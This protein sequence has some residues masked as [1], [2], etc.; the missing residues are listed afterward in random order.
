MKPKSSTTVAGLRGRA[1]ARLKQ[2]RKTQRTDDGGQRSAADT[3]RLLHELQVHQ[4]ELELQN[5][6]LQESRDEAEVAL[7]KYTE[8]YDFAPVGYFSL[9]EQGR[10]LAVNLT[11]AALLGVERS[12]LT[13]RPLQRFVVPASR[14]IFLAFLEKVFAT[15]DKQVCEVSILDEDGVAFWVDL[16]GA[17]LPSPG[18]A[19]LSCRV[20]ASDITALKR[21][22]E[23]QRRL[24]ALAAINRELNLEIVR[25]QA[26]EAALKESEVRQGRLLEQSQHMQ[27]QLRRLSHQI[28]QAH[29]EERKRIS[30]ELH[31][32][33]T[34]TLVGINVHLET[35][36]RA[37]EANPRQL[38]GKIVRTQR[39]VEK[40]VSMVHRFARELRPT[41]LDDL[42][43]VATVHS[44]LKDFTKRT[45]IRVHFTSFASGRIDQLASDARTVFYRVAQ[46]A[47]TN[48]ARHAEA[49]QVKV[50]LLKLPEALCL[51]ISDNGKSFAVEKVMDPKRNQRL[52]LIG[53]RERVEMVGGSLSIE[54]APGQGTTI[55]AQIP[56][57]ARS[58]R[59]KKL[60][61]RTVKTKPFLFSAPVSTMPESSA[62]GISQA[63]ASTQTQLR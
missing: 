3:Q 12:R 45:G 20:A 54:S 61:V 5:A 29:E 34:Q 35:L 56:I 18:G 44:F 25:R 46:E 10:I 42:G 51:E 15:P 55:R 33:V 23:A 60:T 8:L 50:S 39:L 7:E 30:R 47:L 17:A 48:V 57:R 26:V 63:A 36:T 40:A 52:G 13:G 11:G 27:E 14:P 6:E 19:P 62:R 21:A 32:E 41:L 1:E 53:M 31:D 43:L 2:R 49:S 24:E 37:T 16:Q 28:L 58:A 4:V 9:D 38:K 59:K 22:A